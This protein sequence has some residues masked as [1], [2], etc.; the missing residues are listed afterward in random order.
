MEGRQHRGLSLL[1]VAHGVSPRAPRSWWAACWPCPN[2]SVSG[3]SFAATA[4]ACGQVAAGPHRA[5]ER[6]SALGRAAVV[7]EDRYSSVLK[8]ERVHPAVIADGLAELA[9]RWPC[10]GR[11]CRSSSVSLRGATRLDQSAVLVDAY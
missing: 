5:C 6:L 1:A 11:P 4:D 10:A 8:L 2:P 7:V 3:P 9:V